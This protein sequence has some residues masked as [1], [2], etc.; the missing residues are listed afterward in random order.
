MLVVRFRQIDHPLGFALDCDRGQHKL[1]L[2]LVL[3]LLPDNCI[4]S[5]SIGYRFAN[6]TLRYEFWDV[7]GSNES[8]WNSTFDYCIFPEVTFL[9]IKR[10]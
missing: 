2:Q 6:S 4:V 9:N 5:W 3:G 7:V 1:S 8:E 10:E